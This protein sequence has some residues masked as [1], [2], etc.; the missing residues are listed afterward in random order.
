MSKQE[1]CNYYRRICKA[2]GEYT[3][4]EYGTCM[5]CGNFELEFSTEKEIDER[6]NSYKE[7]KE[8]DIFKH[9]YN[10]MYNRK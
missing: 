3:V 9:L 2:C 1:S 4:L 7:F 10:L 6:L 5:H 8:S